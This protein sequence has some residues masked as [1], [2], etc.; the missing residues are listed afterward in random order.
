M[1]VWDVAA[2]D[3]NGDDLRDILV[4][5]SD[6]STEPVTKQLLVYL[7]SIG[8]GYSERPA[9]SL[10][11][12]AESGPVFLAEATGTAPREVMLVKG[13]TIDVFQFVAGDFARTQEVELPSLLPSRL[14]RPIFLRY[15]AEDLNGDGLDEWILPRASGYAI[16][17][18]DGTVDEV[19][20]EVVSNI[21]NR[22]RGRTVIAHEIPS[23][24]SFKMEGEP[25][26]SLAFVT[27]DS[28]VFAHGP[29]WSQ[30]TRF[31]IPLE[32]D[33]RWETARVMSDIDG[34]GLP[35]LMVTQL[36]GNVS[37][38]SLTEIYF[39]SEPYVLPTEASVRIESDGVVGVPDL[40]DLGGDGKEDVLMIG[41]PFSIRN[42]INYLAR[43]KLTIRAE[44]YEFTGGTI[45]T[46]PTSE[47][48]LTLDAPDGQSNMA[49]SFGDFDG[50]GRIDVM[51]G[52]KGDL[53]KV[54]LGHPSKFMESDAWVELRIPTYGEARTFDLNQRGGDDVVLIHPDSDD[55]RRIHV[56]LF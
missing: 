26:K 40:V 30:R 18:P 16:R 37:I 3:V 31:D 20:C 15:A 54:V 9:G 27:E 29:G 47:T 21:G 44:A 10:N 19:S 7:A 12:P 22:G 2:E 56:M 43:G 28:V 48:R 17:H 33:D 5:T 50:D 39:A 41:V 25:Y 32:W 6:E 38:K 8:G 53:M 55:K 36:R 42:L 1:D 51:Y 13:G 23:I 11:L 52:A 4:L 14:D 46:K 45:P 35:D 34:N 24:H 49:Y